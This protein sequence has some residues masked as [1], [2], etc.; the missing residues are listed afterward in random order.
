MDRN[1]R[2]SVAACESYCVLMPAWEQINN[3]AMHVGMGLNLGV[4][5]ANYLRGAWQRGPPLRRLGRR[6][7]RQHEAGA[8]LGRLGELRAP[9]YPG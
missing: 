2:S 1:S 3:N 4:L 8:P 5:R 7:R 6:R 9:Q